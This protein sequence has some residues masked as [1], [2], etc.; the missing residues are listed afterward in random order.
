MSKLLI[1]QTLPCPKIRVVLSS[2]KKKLVV[3]TILFWPSQNIWTFNHR[4]KHTAY[5][6]PLDKR[7]QLSNCQDSKQR[8]LPWLSQ[9]TRSAEFADLNNT[10]NHY[11]NSLQLAHI[12]TVYLKS[13][14]KVYL[15]FIVKNFCYFLGKLPL[16]V[17]EFNY[18]EQYVHTTFCQPFCCKKKL[19][20]KLCLLLPRLSIGQVC[21]AGIS[22][23]SQ[24]KIYRSILIVFFH[25]C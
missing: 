15:C 22:L 17:H 13:V 6:R 7:M 10:N 11:K 5:E 25:Y 12:S 19:V 16:K 18:A 24:K 21:K 3:F 1:I 23:S 14:K 9:I 20:H 4:A 8:L 2:F